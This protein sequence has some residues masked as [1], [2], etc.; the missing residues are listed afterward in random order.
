M[1][2]V[3]LNTLVATFVLGVQSSKAFLQRI[4]RLI[5]DTVDSH[6]AILLVFANQVPNGCGTG[7]RTRAATQDI[8]AHVDAQAISI[9]IQ[10]TRI[11]G[12]YEDA[13]SMD[14]TSAII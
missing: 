9:S 4:V 1:L 14:P 11:T 5:S 7:Y 6:S 13:T 3:T 12:R 2:Q 8:A 10:G